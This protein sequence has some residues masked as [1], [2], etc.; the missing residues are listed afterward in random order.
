LKKIAEVEG[1]VFDEKNPTEMAEKL[2][3]AIGGE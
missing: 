3:K 2:R 1:V